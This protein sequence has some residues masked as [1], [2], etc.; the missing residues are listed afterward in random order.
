MKATQVTAPCAQREKGCIDKDDATGTKP[1]RNNYGPA[2]YTSYRQN[3]MLVPNNHPEPAERLLHP[4][5]G[6]VHN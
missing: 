5:K 1:N 3:F 4:D 6:E 2:A